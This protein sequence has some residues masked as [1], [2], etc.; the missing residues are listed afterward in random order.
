MGTTVLC[1]IDFAGLRRAPSAFT[2]V[3]HFFHCIFLLS[4]FRTA[5]CAAALLSAVSSSNDA[6]EAD[7][8]IAGSNESTVCCIGPN[9]DRCLPRQQPV[10]GMADSTYQLQ[11]CCSSC[12]SLCTCAYRFKPLVVQHA[13]PAD[14]HKIHATASHDRV[15][16]F[17]A[18]N[19]ALLL[20]FVIMLAMLL[21]LQSLPFL[22]AAQPDALKPLLA[23]GFTTI[24]MAAVQTFATK[25]LVP[26]VRSINDS[27]QLKLVLLLQQRMGWHVAAAAFC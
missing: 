13:A 16:A 12:A 15:I 22:K 11:R 5:L 3:L 10:Q 20:T 4:V 7:A 1:S 23:N 9:I 21:P 6:E 18:C 27:K 26:M 2:V 19:H 24:D 25:T 17:S 14:N 8:I